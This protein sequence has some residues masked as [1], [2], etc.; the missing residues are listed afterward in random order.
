MTAPTDP[1]ARALALPIWQ[2]R[3]TG[4]PLGGGITNLNVL[5][6]DSVRK[7]VVRIGDDIPVH[8]IMRFNE[9]AASQAAHAAGVSPKVLY[10]EPGALVI[11]FVEGRTMTA[12]TLRDPALL[13]EALALVTR[14]HR[15]IPRHLRGPALTFWVFQTLRDYAATL[16]DGRSLHGPALSGLLAEAEELERAVGRIELVFGHN[17]LLPANFLHDGQ[18][19]WLIDWDYAGWGSPLF[20]LGGLAANNA[21]DAAQ[22][23]WLLTTYYGTAPDPDLWRRYRAMKAAAALRETMW[24]MVQEIHSDLDFD[25]RAYTAG[26]LDTYRAALAAFRT[27]S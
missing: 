16:R 24:S 23:D 18:R 20:D 12:E 17:D 7:A 11:D 6:T 3:A 22:E 15:D 13:G 25:Y 19:M 8:Q 27:G 21:L 1:V 26:Y 5:V 10:H 4:T 2:G 14:T 9:L